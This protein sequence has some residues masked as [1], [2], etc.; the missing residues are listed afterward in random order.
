MSA[1]LAIAIL[2]AVFAG[3]CVSVAEGVNPFRDRP[4]VIGRGV[5][6]VSSPP[7]PSQISTVLPSLI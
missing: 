2:V 4:P 7:L 6:V 5:A 1:Y 3:E